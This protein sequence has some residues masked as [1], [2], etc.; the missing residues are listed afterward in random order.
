MTLMD[1]T[2]DEARELSRIAYVVSQRYEHSPKDIK[3]WGRMVDELKTMCAEA[4][5]RIEV[6]PLS[7]NGNWI[8]QVDIVG[9]IDKHLQKI[10]DD[11]GTDVERRVFEMRD[12]DSKKLEK[13]GVN[14]NLVD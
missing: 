2:I 4:G 7:E 14:L 6:V 12:T 10:V 11:E 13:E 9:R 3:V 8:P 5:F 1:V